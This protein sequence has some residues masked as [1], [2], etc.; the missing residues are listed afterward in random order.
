LPTHNSIDKK[1]MTE[2]T[3]NIKGIS[4]ENK[5]GQLVTAAKIHWG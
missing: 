1:E 5:K 3:E 4:L 2:R